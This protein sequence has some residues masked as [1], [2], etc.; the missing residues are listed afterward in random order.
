MFMLFLLIP[1]FGISQP[2][3]T[4]EDLFIFLMK[5]NVRS[6]NFNISNE[7]YT[8]Y[9][10]NF[11]QA[12]FNRVSNNEFER[13]E[14]YNKTIT[15]IK[16]KVQNF[17]FSKLFSTSA[18]YTD[19]KEYDF[20]NESFELKY[21]P[22][23][24]AY[25]LGNYSYEAQWYNFNND[26]PS[27][28]FKIK[29]DKAKELMNS[30]KDSYGNTDR[31]VYLVAKINLM[32]MEVVNTG[33]SNFDRTKLLFNILCHQIDIYSDK[34]LNYKI[35]TIYANTNSVNSVTGNSASINNK[36]VYNFYDNQRK[37]LTTK[38]NISFEEAKTLASAQQSVIQVVEYKSGTLN[39]PVKSYYADGALCE[40]ANYVNNNP[41]PSNINGVDI[42]YH[43]NGVKAYETNF[44]KGKIFQYQAGWF[45]S[46]KLKYI[47]GYDYEGN[48][49][50]PYIEYNEIGQR[51]IQNRYYGGRL[52]ENESGRNY[53]SAFTDR[54]VTQF[55]FVLPDAGNIIYKPQ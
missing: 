7:D 36:T 6:Q 4:T 17:T 55:G 21:G 20:N 34:N 10:K 15:K 31:R 18:S 45:E 46:G 54:F 40:V 19:L 23:L 35:A 30:K 8:F 1:L 32:D 50:G 11:D 44:D 12:N 42:I 2:T 16:T 51:I 39:L 14:Y 24:P 25:I 9:C 37:L 28:K 49:A 33:Q 38:D 48:K 27:L 13:Q 52:I 41:I 26:F 43:R 22:G 47:Q 5:R 3:F 53:N 29:P